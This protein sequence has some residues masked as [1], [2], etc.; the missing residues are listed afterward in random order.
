MMAKD[1]TQQDRLDELSRHYDSMLW[2]VTSLWS[3]AIG[4]LLVYLT[5]NFDTYL[6]LFGIGLTVCAMSFA[7][8]FRRLRRF[9]HDQMSADIHK[10]YISHDRFRQWHVFLILFCSMIVLW[11]RLLIINR[12]VWLCIW[13]IIGVVAIGLIFLIWWLGN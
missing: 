1:D 4:G 8:S 10:L 12:P 3:A 2:T 11:M 6:V 13:I 9:V 5:K 7:T